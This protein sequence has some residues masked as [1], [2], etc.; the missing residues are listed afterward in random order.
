MAHDAYITSAFYSGT[1]KGTA[2]DAAD[3]DRIALRARRGD[4][5]PHH[6]PNP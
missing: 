1:Y 2:I 6:E 3:F 4:R 5:Q